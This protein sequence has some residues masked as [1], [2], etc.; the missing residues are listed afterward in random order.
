MAAWRSLAGVQRLLGLPRRAARAAS[1]GGAASSAALQVPPRA[2]PAA[3]TPAH[4]EEED[5]EVSVYVKNPDWHGFDTDPV[6][7][8]WNMRLVFFFGFSITIVVGT[9]FVHY[10]PERGLVGWSRREAERQIKY[11]EAHGLP[12]LD[13]NYYDPSKIVLPPEDEE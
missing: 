5:E 6:V 4:A 12:L 7:D 8:L 11:R 13:P 10:L 9:A 3:L 2:S 1:S